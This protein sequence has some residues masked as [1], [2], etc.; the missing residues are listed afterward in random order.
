[1][2]RQYDLLDIINILSFLIGV[3]NLD[4]NLS[5]ND[6]QDLQNDFSNKADMLLKEIHGHLEKQDDKLDMILAEVTK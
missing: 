1:M 3:Q 2:N 4:E 5:Q 6:K